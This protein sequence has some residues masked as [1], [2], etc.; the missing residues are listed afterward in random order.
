MS[1]A[2]QQTSPPVLGYATPQADGTPDFINAAEET[3]ATGGSPND[4]R[5][6]FRRSEDALRYYCKSQE[7]R[8]SIVSTQANDRCA[9]CDVSRAPGLLIIRWRA[10]VLLR[11][12]EFR[13]SS[14]D[15]TRDF[16]THHRICAA[17]YAHH[18]RRVQR[19]RGI[20]IVSNIVL[21]L[22][23]VAVITGDR[24]GRALRIQNRECSARFSFG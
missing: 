23:A 1:Q 20:E 19:R 10:T 18:R 4:I 6:F 22:G 9:S 21:V 7:R 2:P 17:C 24:W 5:D 12:A 13:V 8:F 15:T 14:S 16:T 11:S 3:I